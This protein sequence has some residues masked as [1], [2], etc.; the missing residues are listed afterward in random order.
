MRL[1]WLTIFTFFFL[2][3]GGFSANA[4]SPPVP[5]SKKQTLGSIENNLKAG[6]AEKKNLEIK[7]Q[8]IE[9]ELGTT[10]NRLI[11][12]S[13]SI[14]GNEKTLQELEQKIEKLQ[15]EQL[16]L[17]DSLKNDRQ[18]IAR[19]VLA[20][21]RLRRVP[22]EALIIRPEAP[23]RAA[24]SAMLMRDIIPALHKQAESL[25]VNLGNLST[26][27]ADLEEKRK[28]ALDTSARLQGEHKKLSSLVDKRE[29][30]YAS[31]QSDLKEQEEN[32]RRISQQAKSLQ[33]LVKKLDEESARTAARKSVTKNKN[34]AVSAGEGRM[35]LTGI[36]RIGYNQADA[37]GA[38]S[39]GL[40][41]EGVG[42]A[43]I[44]APMA[45]TVRF[46]GHF[47]NYG[48]MIIVEHAGGYHSLIAGL[49]KIDTVVGQSVSAGEPVGLLHHADGAEKPS[50][51]YE[52]RLNGRPVNP[53]QRFADL[54]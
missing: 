2:L 36:I 10:K 26:I 42:G 49:E 37:F 9:K 33:D 47:K 32:V 12:L 38:P 4:E 11:D 8:K 39:Q 52:L 40:T 50:L 18:S 22:P 20:L 1:S 27:T 16:A 28:V 30:L 19:L 44:V 5:A 43:L 51:Y 15:D 3:S 31:T 7:V 23:Y 6:Q 48:N 46:A 24:Q 17:E 35:P 13:S 21:E 29:Q 14:Q 54:G 34:P 41:I 45:G 25:R 53:A